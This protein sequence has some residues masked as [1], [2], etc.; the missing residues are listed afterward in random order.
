MFQKTRIRLAALNTLVLF[1]ILNLFGGVIY[2][3]TSN[4]LY[5]GVDLTLLAAAD[6]LKAINIRDWGLVPV[7]PTDRRVALLLWG[8]GDQTVMQIPSDVF[9]AADLPKLEAAAGK[10]GFTNVN[11]SDGHKYRSLSISVTQIAEPSDN[12]IP[13]VTVQLVLN[14]DPEAHMLNN[15]IAIVIIGGLLAGIVSLLVGLF[16]ADRALI[17]IKMAWDKQQEFVADASHELRTPLAVMQGHI[18]LLFRHPDHTIEQDSA[19]I[20]AVL[21]EV[22][23]MIKMVTQLLT[24]ARSDSNQLELDCAEFRLDQL[25][26]D[27]T[28]QFAMLTEIKE[29]AVN[30][31]LDEE[32][33][34]YGDKERLKQLLLILLDNA[35]KFTPEHGIITVAGSKYK[36]GVQII[37]ADT[38]IGISNDDLPFV[39]DRF[40]RGDKARSREGG[41]GLGLALAKWIV[42][43]HN[44][45]IWAES[46]LGEGT[47]IYITL[48]VK[49]AK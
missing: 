38:G 5:R 7:R 45:E 37:V 23:R 26:R 22:K 41:T 36:H 16:L 31:T 24:L 17:P 43:A 10:D 28:E 46:T 6:H 11:T 3:Y 8:K 32:I 13:V 27:T 47:S 21:Y 40:F 44:G 42:D 29:I 35:L 19:K 15:L 18:E 14:I 49:R 34:F 9:S 39:F 48:P 2:L 30:T 33:N 25:L 20:S 1:V 4:N 12:Q